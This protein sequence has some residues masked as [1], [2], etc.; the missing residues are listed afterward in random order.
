MI[1]QQLWHTVVDA[2]ALRDAPLAVS[3]FGEPLV[4]WRDHGAVHAWADR[5]PH[6]GA[7]LSLGRVLT[8]LQGPRLEC[9]YHGWQFAGGGRC[10]HV[11]AAPDFDP[12]AGHAGSAMRP[13][14][15]RM[16]SRSRAAWPTCSCA[17]P[18]TASASPARIAAMIAACS[19][20]VASA[21]PGISL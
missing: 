3:L 4:L 18:A 15:S 20:N 9:P 12:P 1:E 8:T 5:C 16:R 11:P 14:E 21:R 6:R 7:R 13:D 17:A 2:H 10:R 19:V